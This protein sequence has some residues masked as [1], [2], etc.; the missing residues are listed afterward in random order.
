V[1]VNAFGDHR[2]AM[3]CACGALFCARP[4]TLRGGDC[5]S[6]SYEDF[7]RDYAALGGKVE[8]LTE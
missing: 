7:W 2:I 3:L 5:V 1:T 8:E 4:V 6:K